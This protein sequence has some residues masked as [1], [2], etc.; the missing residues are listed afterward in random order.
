M[1][2]HGS[3]HS[4]RSYDLTSVGTQ[5]DLETKNKLRTLQEVIIPQVIITPDADKNIPPDWNIVKNE[6]E[7]G[8]TETSNSGV[9]DSSQSSDLRIPSWVNKENFQPV[10]SE[11]YP[12]IDEVIAFKAYPAV[13]AGENYST[14]MLRVQIVIKLK[15]TNTIDLSFMLKLVH[16]NK[17]MNDMLEQLNFF[18]VENAVYN[19]VIPEMEEMYR[20]AGL[21]IHFGAKAY[22]LP[23]NSATDYYVLLEDLSLSNYKNVNCVESLDMK[24]TQAVLRKLALFHAASVYRVATKGPYSSTFSPDMVSPMSRGFISQMFSSMKKPFMDNLKIYENGE[25][26]E[27]AMVSTHKEKCNT[28]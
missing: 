6:Q 28:V 21:N 9:A 8:T 23:L 5:K 25:K 26:Y 10:L 7:T 17:D 4:P 22:Q 2:L 12:D 3:K 15:D 16:D 27:A 20:L 18:N 14:L 24:H 11:L 1:G 19:T 13:A